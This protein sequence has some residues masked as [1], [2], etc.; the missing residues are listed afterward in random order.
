MVIK[1][2]N[3]ELFIA[4]KKNF[5]FFAEFNPRDRKVTH[6]YL[7]EYPIDLK[8]WYCPDVP[9]AKS[10]R[11]DFLIRNEYQFLK[12]LF[13]EQEIKESPHLLSLSN[14]YDPMKYYLKVFQNFRYHSD[15][16]VIF[17]EPEKLNEEYKDFL[18]TYMSDRS[19]S[20]HIHK[21]IKEFKL[22]KS[23]NVTLRQK[24]FA[25]IHTTIP[26]KIF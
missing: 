26:D 5:H 10:S 8:I 22:L 25:L 24:V 17:A 21:H 15:H 9:I 12:I 20:Q 7:C 4:E 2:N 19:T 13:T 18:L 11:L 14:Y 1:P 23:Q 6:C 16:R 3:S